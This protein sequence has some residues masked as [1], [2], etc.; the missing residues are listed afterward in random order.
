MSTKTRSP[1]AG[2]STE[3]P[4]T[5]ESPD[6]PTGISLQDPE[7][8][9]RRLFDMES[10]FRSARRAQGT[11]LVGLLIGVMIAAIVGLQVVIP[12]VSDAMANLSGTEAT[13]AGLIPLFVVLLI[14]ISLA[15]PLMRRI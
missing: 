9:M 2:S 1:S 8:W 14:L 10:E 7:T 5:T 15:S 11:N 4:E 6:S 3:S 13:I 12:V